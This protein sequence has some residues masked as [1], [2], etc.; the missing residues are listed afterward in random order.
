MLVITASTFMI[1]IAILAQAGI[2][3]LHN[4]WGHIKELGPFRVLF[5]LI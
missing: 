1:T 5:K 3:N 4:L 2:V